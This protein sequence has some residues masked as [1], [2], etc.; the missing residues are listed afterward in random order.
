MFDDLTK[1]YAR[2]SAYVTEVNGVERPE[3]V[4]AKRLC[5][6]SGDVITRSWDAAGR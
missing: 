1:K 5:E 4:V 2:P 3:L 6:L